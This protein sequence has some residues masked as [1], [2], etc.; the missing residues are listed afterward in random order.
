METP[1]YARPMISIMKK[2]STNTISK[3]RRIEDTIVIDPYF[4]YLNINYM[5]WHSLLKYYKHF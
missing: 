3:K 4:I 2:A 5:Q 1:I